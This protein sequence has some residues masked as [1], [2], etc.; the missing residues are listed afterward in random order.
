MR[1]FTAAQPRAPVSRAAFGASRSS[2]RAPKRQAALLV[3]A[4]GDDKSRAS[5]SN[6]QVCDISSLLHLDWLH[7]QLV[8]VLWQQLSTD[9]RHVHNSLLQLCVSPSPAPIIIDRRTRFKLV[10]ELCAAARHCECRSIV[11][12]ALELEVEQ[13]TKVPIIAQHSSSGS[14]TSNTAPITLTKLRPCIHIVSVFSRFPCAERTPILSAVT[15]RSHHWRRDSESVHGAQR[16]RLRHKPFR[17]S[18]AQFIAWAS[19]G[20]P[21]G[22]TC[23]EAVVSCVHGAVLPKRSNE[24]RQ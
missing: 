24:S 6:R 15:L 3:R 12:G 22:R 11:Q 1:A 16:K 9:M 19:G 20:R 14:S 2:C 5:H 17:T 23:V 13:R 18:E 8:Q 21:C 10:C 7:R 4:E